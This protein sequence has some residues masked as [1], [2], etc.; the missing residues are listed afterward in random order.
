MRY[1][2]RPCPGFASV[3]LFA[4]LECLP[5]P[6]PLAQSGWS[7]FLSSM[8]HSRGRCAAASQDCTPGDPDGSLFCLRPFVRAVSPGKLFPCLCAW[9]PCCILQ[10]APNFHLL[11]SSLPASC[12]SQPPACF[13]PSSC[14]AL[15]YV[16]PRSRL[17]TP[18]R[19]VR[20]RRVYAV[21]RCLLCARYSAWHPSAS[22][23]VG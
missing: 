21:P 11:K 16:F 3:G 10:G 5:A 12:W 22:V 23:T 19:A 18:R 9:R 6:G 4:F 13:L 20:G 15:N 1:R 14:R 7:R 17:P 2:C 8:D